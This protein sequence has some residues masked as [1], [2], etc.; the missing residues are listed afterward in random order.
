MQQK[1]TSEDLINI[2]L[3]KGLISEDQAKDIRVKEGQQRARVLRAKAT[4]LAA[5]RRLNYEVTPAELIASFR[6]KS[7]GKHGEL[8]DEDKLTKLVAEELGFPYRKIDPLKLDM[9]LI[10]STISRP[11]A[12]KHAV[13]ALEKDDKTLVVAAADP[14]DEE[15]F[16]SLQRITGLKIVPVM[17][18][19]SDI[20]KVITEVYGFRTS[21]KAA[22]RDIRAGVDIG[23]LEQFVKLKA[24]EDIE[25]TDKHI[26]NAVDYM[27]HYAFDQRAS[28][29]HIEPKRNHSVVR[30]RIDGILH[31]VFTLPKAVH[32]A[33]VSRL[34][35]LARLDIAEKRRPQDGRIKTGG[36]VGE[37]ELRISTLP[38]A[39]G[40][41]IV[42]RIFDPQ[43]LVQDLS[44]LG[45]F[46][47]ELE[48]FE[49]FIAKPH[50]ILLVTGPT[51]SGKTTTLYSTLK[52]LA[53]ED[54][55][56]TTIEDPIEM[57]ME[58]FNQVAVHPRIGITFANALRTILRQDPDIIMVGEIRDRETAENA[59]QAA[60]TGHLVL[61]TLHTND[62]A[63]S[64]TRLV[65]L[66]IKPYLVA[67]TLVGVVAQRLVRKVCPHCAQETFLTP[68]QIQ[69]LNIKIPEGQDGKLPVKYGDGCVIC[70][71]TGLYGRTG[72]FEVLPMTNRIYKLVVS[73]AP[74]TEIT[75]AAR[76]DGMMTLRECAIKKLAQG[77]TSFEE[78][79][80]VTVG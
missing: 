35:M 80:R 71:G 18:T 77:T 51:G 63:S 64:I 61:S 5:R 58:H 53:T 4:S 44:G 72:V 75:K 39:F 79:I 60:L 70:R 56:I 28:D 76:M 46:P 43:V 6:L 54:V 69:A 17:S 25:A 59:V 42:I 48:L 1:L 49:S 8:L 7:P 41:K 50:G 57:V 68:D 74:S 27:L 67:S 14:L 9:K 11:F 23:N 15:L 73:Q 16:E 24:V 26:V 10:T 65:E 34:K 36:A 47:R 13:V 62:T 12:R 30:L 78:V 38:V 66:G 29:V 22:E 52:L 40:E 21:V 45:F 19:K 3:G 37:T 32:P 33:F 31:D 20:L 55:N 2:L